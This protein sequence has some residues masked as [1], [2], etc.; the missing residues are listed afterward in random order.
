[1]ST[2]TNKY[3]S[4]HSFISAKSLGKKI[5]SRCSVFWHLL[6]GYGKL[7]AGIVFF[8][9]LL[10]V[11]SQVFLGNVYRIP[12]GESLEAPGREHWLGT[13]DLGIDL[14]AQICYGAAISMKVG[15]SA[16][17]LAG[18]GGSILGILAGYYGR[19]V[20]KVIMGICDIIMTIPQLPLMIVLGA[21]LGSS[22]KNII[23]VIAFMSW[24]APARIARSKVFSISHE[25]YITAAKCYGAGFWH[26]L[27]KHIIPGILPV[28]LVSVIRIISHAITAEAGLSF[29][30]LGDPTSK[31]WGVI[32]NRSINFSGIFFTDYW[33][34][35]IVFP[36]LALLLLITAIAFL[37]RD[38]EKMVNT[39]L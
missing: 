11:L 33:K 6:S 18:I 24:A 21:F 3:K 39:K 22:V 28:I 25:T 1:M 14:A 20:D 31:S 9:L 5:C 16:A 4:I 27:V 30:G 29:L 36:L 26:L 34:W 2:I 8:M 7:G 32:L 19:W 17:L 12:S 38:M 35:W 15:I 10:A 37:C 23:L 13:D